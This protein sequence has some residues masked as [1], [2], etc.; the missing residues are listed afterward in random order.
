MTNQLDQGPQAREAQ[1][2]GR[3]LRHRTIGAMMWAYGSYVGGRAVILL[4]TAVLARILAPSAFGVVTLALVFMTFLETLQDLGLT[5]ALIVA[6]PEQEHEQAQTVFVWTIAIAVALAALASIVAQP[7]AHF[8]GYAQ[9]QAIIPVLGVGFVIEALGATHNALARK[10]LDYRARA[11][12][13]GSY[14]L[15]RGASS[16][17]LALTGF[18]AWSLVLGYLVGTIAHTA[19][20]WTLVAFRP[21]L[22]FTHRH[23]RSLV[24]FGG[25]LTLVDL[26]AA[27]VQNI[28]YLFIGRVLGSTA[29]GLYMMGFRLPEL[30]IMNIA[31]VA[32]GV[33]FPA[34]SELRRE[35]LQRGFLVSLRFTVALV[36]P[37]GLGLAILARPF[38]LD[39]FGVRWQESIPVLR[40]LSLF[41]VLTTINIPAGTVYKVTGRAWIL[42]ALQIP[43]FVAQ[44]TSLALIGNRGIVTVAWCMT[45]SQ[46]GIAL[47]YLLIAHRVVGVSYRSVAS[48]VA[49]PTAAAL[50][51][52]AAVFVVE[53]LVHSPWPALIVGVVVGAF[54]YGALIRMLAKDLADQVLEVVRRPLLARRRSLSLGNS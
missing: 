6:G 9:L 47:A 46:A 17:A 28:D 25:M 14:V 19:L 29:L 11:F 16:I 12:A 36:L 24:R 52:G 7:A 10:R 49:G 8:F 37:I 42:V 4:V 3:S 30:L 32:A 23:L 39:L 1:P 51:M 45:V 20:L 50:G 21:T 53:R 31:V 38:V 13:E 44:I 5:Q 41:A 35:N 26:L 40:I 15:A 54:I 22:R 34:Y 48:V 33:L 2:D 18:G 27:L 43:Y